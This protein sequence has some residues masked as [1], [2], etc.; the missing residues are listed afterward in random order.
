MST[1]N[2]HFE[3]GTFAAN[4][5][6]G[7]SHTMEPD[8]WDA[9]W[10]NAAQAC[11]V[12]EDAGLDFI[13]PMTQWRGFEGAQAATDGYIQE[14]LT[15]A[16]AT[17]AVTNRIR[18]F[19]TVSAPFV[20]PVW[21]AKQ[22]ITCN[23]IGEGRFAGINIVSGYSE[24]EFAVFG[25]EMLPHDERY[26]YT[27]E[28]SEIVKRVWR[29]KE[30][31]DYNGKYFQ[32]KNAQALPP[33]REPVPMIV[34]AGS[35]PKGK[36]FASQHGDAWFTLIFR[37]ENGFEGLAEEIA[38]FREMAGRDIKVYASGHIICRETE[39]ETDAY[40][41]SI[42][43]NADW[44]AKKD[45]MEQFMSGAQSIPQSEMDVLGER[46]V[47]GRSTCLFRGTPE[48]IVEEFLVLRD[49]GLDGLGLAMQ[50]YIQDIPII[51]EKLLPL[52]VKNGLRAE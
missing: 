15:W 18:V 37:G 13:L 34:N 7:L 22:A 47:T 10:R 44:G 28:W 14:S 39:E 50:D 35:S 19:A 26:D 8:R 9:S 45:W 52:M 20:H 29:E 12:A 51:R 4:N 27:A 33:S 2:H 1:S 49:A 48:Q 11:R 40:Y 25:V 46:F 21:A 38:K 6:G 43:N 16:A 36:E 24:K 3:L 23:D 30:P 32:L 5:W 31:F 41:E 17:L 42:V